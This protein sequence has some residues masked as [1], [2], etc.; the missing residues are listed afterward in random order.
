MLF[1]RVH[2][3]LRPSNVFH[4]NA[5]RHLATANSFSIPVIDFSK[6][7]SASSREEKKQTANEIVSA[8]KESGF[9]YIKNHGVT[10]G[11][12]EVSLHCI[13]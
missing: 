2:L 8:F 6:F 9:I 1:A 12:S 4:L 13:S 3:L 5:K 7:R 11:M 10:P